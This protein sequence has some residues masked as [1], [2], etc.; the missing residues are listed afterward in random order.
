MVEGQDIIA[1][2]IS[3]SLDILHNLFY[4]HPSLLSLLYDAYEARTMNK[5]LSIRNQKLTG[6]SK[7]ALCTI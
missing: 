4:L 6:R 1:S 7:A 5:I 3:Q 2:E